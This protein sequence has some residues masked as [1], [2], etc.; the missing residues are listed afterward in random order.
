MAKAKT[1][2]LFLI[3]GSPQGRMKATLSNWTGVAYLLP[4][5]KLKE[6]KKRP[7]LQKAGVYLLIGTD[8]NEK[9][10]VYVGQARKRKNENG[11]LGRIIEHL[12]DEK[13]DYWTHAIALVTSNDTL[14]PTEIS[15][16]ENRFTSM[17]LEA[18]RYSVVNGNDPSSGTPT[19]EKQAELEEFIDYA[20]IIVG[21]LGYKVFEP[22]DAPFDNAKKLQTRDETEPLLTMSYA[23]VTAQG[24]QTSDGFVVLAGSTLR[25]E[26]DFTPSA[27]LASKKNREKYRD[28]IE[29][30][31]L[32]S[33]ALFSSPSGA[34]MFV[35]GASLNGFDLWKDNRGRSLKQIEQ[36]KK[37]L[38]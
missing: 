33:D 31:C 18:G 26:E 19:E 5:T 17:A 7:D 20:R 22:L 34:A 21:A 4:R 25:K 12:V 30:N 16:L 9:L 38:P 29:N 6:S 37:K 1:I 35:G 32:V 24:R 3:D 8:D 23:K 15:Y 11:I 2:Q 27:G 10:K 28:I 13:L 14:G 36:A